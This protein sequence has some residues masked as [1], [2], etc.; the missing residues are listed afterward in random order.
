MDIGELFKQAG[1]AFV[2]IV[3]LFMLWFR[4]LK[5]SA[6][7]GFIFSAVVL[8]DRLISFYISQDAGLAFI[9]LVIIILVL[10]EYR[11]KPT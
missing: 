7:A 6:A 8:G 4:D 2:I 9:L 3:T 1:L 5:A 10:I 11:Q